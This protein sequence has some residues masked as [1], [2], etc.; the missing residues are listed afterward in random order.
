MSAR[1]Q[2]SAEYEHAYANLYGRTMRKSQYRRELLPDP[3][4]YYAKHLDTLHR[5]GEWADARCPLHE[6][7]NPSLSVNLNHGGFI[8]RG[9]GAQG[10]DVLAFHRHFKDMDFVTA[11]K[12][13]GAWGPSHD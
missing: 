3:A 6:D 9:C 13:L 12:D 5:R 8:C 1:Y 7:H 11:A 4:D 2:P 10:A